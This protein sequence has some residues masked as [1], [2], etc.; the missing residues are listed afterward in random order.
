[1]NDSELTLTWAPRLLSV[2]RIVTGLL[3]LEHG[4]QKLL[5]FPTRVADAPGAVVA[6]RRARL[7]WKSWAAC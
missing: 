6:A 7:A 3:F 2:L 4:T 1:M 5:A